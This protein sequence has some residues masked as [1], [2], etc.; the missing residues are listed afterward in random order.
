MDFILFLEVRGNFCGMMRWY[1]VMRQEVPSSVVNL[2]VV[3]ILQCLDVSYIYIDV[4]SDGVSK[5]CK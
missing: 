1:T 3:H 2:L 4:A 5:I